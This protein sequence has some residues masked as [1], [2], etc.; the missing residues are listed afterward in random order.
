MRWETKLLGDVIERTQQVDPTRSPNRQFSY[1]DVSGVSNQSFTVAEPVVL[2]GKDAPSRA[3]KQ[4]RAGDVLFATVRPTLKRIA[5]IPEEL[6]GQIASTGYFVFRPKPEL[7]NRFLFYFLLSDRFQERMEGL[8]KGASY[9]AVTDAEVR[10][11]NIPLPPL[12]EQQRIVSKLDA[13]FAAL[14]EAEANVE[15]NRAN[16]RELFESYLN[17]VFEGKDGWV[18]VRLGDLVD[19]Q[20]GYAFKSIS[21]T[22]SGHFLIRIS[23]VQDGRVTLDN[24]KYVAIDE[25]R[26]ERF[27]LDEGDILVSLTGNIGRVGLVKAEHLPAALNQRV[28][29]V[30]IRERKRIQQSFLF[31]FL[32]STFFR[33]H[34]QNAGHGAAQQNVS[35]SEIAEVRFNMPPF[36]EQQQVMEALGAIQEKTAELESTYAQKLLELGALKKSILGAAFRGEL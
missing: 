34:L 16:A 27:I 10:S 12:P 19:I 11:Q 17:G 35:T 9:P 21:Y 32:R 15:R 29:R 2:Y 26:K 20:N 5:I 18:E 33:E 30:T 22:N 25:P 24:P 31:F 8:Q 36:D 1:I 6:D 13:A 14:S 3:R 7:T 28:A 23:N 4:I